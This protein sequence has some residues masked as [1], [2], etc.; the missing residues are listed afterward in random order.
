M[1]VKAV[2]ITLF[3]IKKRTNIEMLVCLVWIFQFKLLP[4][5]WELWR[6][7]NQS[8]DSASYRRQSINISSSE[9]D[10]LQE[11]QI[12]QGFIILGQNRLNYSSW[13]RNHASQASQAQSWLCLS[14]SWFGH[15]AHMFVCTFTHCELGQLL[16]W[17]I[18]SCSEPANLHRRAGRTYGLA[19]NYWP[20]AVA[21][22]C[23]AEALFL[24][25]VFL[26]VF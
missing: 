13:M 20:S 11:P 7:A 6:L 15:I 14:F 1:F 9:G 3:V 16:V 24:W 25:N 2:V 22:T 10:K 5:T 21:I 8:D 17:W 4:E 23:R 12:P 26:F 19:T 18:H